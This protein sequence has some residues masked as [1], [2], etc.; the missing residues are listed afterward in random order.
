MIF[1]QFYDHLIAIKAKSAFDE[2]QIEQKRH[3]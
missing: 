2:F 1:E 3:L